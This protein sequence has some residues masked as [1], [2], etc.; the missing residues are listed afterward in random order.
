MNVI[1]PSITAID[2]L[3]NTR[4]GMTQEEVAERLGIS[5]ARVA[6]IEASALEKLR[7]ENMPELLALRAM[8]NGG[9]ALELRRIRDAS[10]AGCG[11]SR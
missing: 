3:G 1:A 5:P 6:E 4:F 11:E 2:R 7:R 8:A 9:M 10:A